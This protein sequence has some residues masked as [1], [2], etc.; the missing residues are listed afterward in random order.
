MTPELPDGRE[1]RHG[2]WKKI[3]A[4]RWQYRAEREDQRAFLLLELDGTGCTDSMSGA[5]FPFRAIV[6]R[7]G[8]RL[9]G[10]ALEGTAAYPVRGE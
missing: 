5:R 9:E 2:T 3:E 8:H 6:L 10:C 1:Y 4:H 7:D